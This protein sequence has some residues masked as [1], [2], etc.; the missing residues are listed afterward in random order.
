MIDGDHDESE[1]GHVFAEA[2]CRVAFDLDVPIVLVVGASGETQQH[3]VRI[4]GVL[5][6]EEPC[7]LSKLLIGTDSSADV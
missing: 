5:R 6:N 1:S 3:S 4:G 2:V 7:L